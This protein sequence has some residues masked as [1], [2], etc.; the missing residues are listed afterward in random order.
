[1]ITS[2]EQ[3]IRALEFEGPERIPRQ[4]WLLPWAE[5]KYPAEVSRLKNR[6]PDDLVTAPA[7]YLSPT[8]TIGERYNTGTYS[9]EWG[10]VFH[11]IHDGVIGIVKEPLVASWQDINK[12]KTPEATLHLDKKTINRFCTSTDQFVLGGTYVRPWERYQ[13]LRT[14]EQ[15]LIDFTME[16]PEAAHLLHIIH[17]HYCREVEAWSDTAVDAITLMDDWGMQQSLMLSPLL[18]RKYFRPLYKDYVDIARTKGKYVFLHSDGYITEII[19]DFIDVGIDAL[20]SQLF[21]MDIDE[22]G[23]KFAGKITFWGEIDRQHI[24]SSGTDRE[25]RDAVHRVF[26]HLYARGGI[27]GQCEFGPGAK[28]ENVWKVFEEW[29]KYPT[30]SVSAT[31]EGA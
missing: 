16:L 3:V 10:C 8:G 2:R 31:K 9:D 11:N 23:R 27:I 18:F 14:M 21:C 25:V 4:L 29:E 22:L 19:Q 15:A 1:M 17:E 12:I 28:P 24:L 26:S 20:N 5:R 13:F 7:L 30:P 6:F